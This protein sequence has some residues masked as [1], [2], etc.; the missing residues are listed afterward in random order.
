M[1]INVTVSGN[2][3]SIKRGKMVT[4]S[5]YDTKREFDKRRLMRLEQ[6]RHQSKGIAENIRNKL[7]K[8]H[9]NKLS[10]LEKQ[11]EVKLKTWQAHKLLDLQNQYQEALSEIGLGHKQ[12]E[13]K[14]KDDEVYFENLDH[15]DSVAKERGKIAAERLQ[16]KKN[17]VNL[18]KAAPLQRK[19]MSKD[20][21]NERSH[22]MMQGKS[23]INKKVNEGFDSD[24]ENQVPDL[25]LTSSTCDCS[26]TENSEKSTV[27]FSKE[28]QTT[29]RAST[30]EKAAQT[31]PQEDVFLTAKDNKCPLDNR[32]SQRIKRRH[33]QVC[34]PDYCD[35]VEKELP[36]SSHKNVCTCCNCFPNR[37]E[38][39]LQLYSTKIS[40]E[41]KEHE[42]PIKNQ[43]NMTSH[44]ICCNCYHRHLDA[45]HTESSPNRLE[46]HALNKTDISPKTIKHE[47]KPQ[48]ENP[49]IYN[50]S[51]NILTNKQKS[52][53]KSPSK[54]HPKAQ[55][56]I[57][58][59]SPKEKP[60]IPTKPKVT[61]RSSKETPQNTRKPLSPTKSNEN[62]HYYDHSNRFA[63]NYVPQKPLVGK[64]ADEDLDYSPIDNEDEIRE[65]MRRRD[66][67]AHV[68][69]QLAQERERAQREYREL[70][71]K[72]PTL[73]KQERVGEIGLDKA[74][75]H[76][77]RERLEELERKR[78]N[79]LDN[80][81]EEL[82]VR[83][84]KPTVVTLPRKNHDESAP[85]LNLG[86]YWD[87]DRVIPPPPQTK[88]N[89]MEKLSSMLES[90]T[91][92]KEQLLQEIE[93]TLPG[94]QVVTN[95]SDTS[96]GNGKLLK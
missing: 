83:D 65:K 67:E 82:F 58:Q 60:Q 20:V 42:E 51:S 7:K 64:I 86:S 9:N 62:V 73:Q 91:S 88:M 5:D 6:V 59:K 16:I 38:G 94:T 66:Y 25:G 15:G 31:L 61:L 72:L 35:F 27:K 84:R 48:Q 81:Y 76:M 2:P 87:E 93:S 53:Q 36:A 8:T 89:R 50:E 45:N 74:K 54:L 69:G 22:K 77:S 3:I 12:A 46:K 39:E 21:E 14:Q 32:I 63:K 37:Q 29:F 1:S 68:R 96:G 18:K 10:E 13:Q 34:Q 57:G 80:A 47:E 24:S 19:N 17:K 28:Q 30:T 49:K 26:E 11:G 78:Q 40:S 85:S 55:T 23:K 56:S 4:T 52:Q 90:L 70:L 33:V 41:A 71:R 44:C 43:T 79:R 92:Q 95:G 75:Y